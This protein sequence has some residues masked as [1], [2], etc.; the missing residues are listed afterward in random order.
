MA[1]FGGWLRSGLRVCA[2]TSQAQR[3]F[4]PFSSSSG[5]GDANHRDPAASTKPDSAVPEVAAK[6]SQPQKKKVL[7]GVELAVGGYK[8]NRSVWGSI[9]EAKVSDLARR[10]EKLGI[11]ASDIQEQ[12]VRGSGRGGQKMNKT[13]SKV[14][15]TH[16]P[17]GIQVACQTEREQSINR[18]LA[19]RE[20]VSRLESD[21]QKSEGEKERERIRKLKAR[22]KRRCSSSLYFEPPLQP[23]TSFLTDTRS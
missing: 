5:E 10:I 19:M 2:P 23:L 11:L 9:S 13:A 1:L 20:L 16:I 6:R 17:T 15:I 3:L 18:F 4:R 12:F 21:D 14:R 8:V 7:S 22:A